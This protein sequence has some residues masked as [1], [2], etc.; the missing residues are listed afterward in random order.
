MKF[1]YKRLKIYI[2]FLLTIQLI[3]SFFLNSTLQVEEN[4]RKSIVTD[5]YTANFG[6]MEQVM[7]NYDF[8]STEKGCRWKLKFTNSFTALK[9]TMLKSWYKI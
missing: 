6:M 8:S 4:L 2:D 1:E 5:K 7:E 9:E 3:K